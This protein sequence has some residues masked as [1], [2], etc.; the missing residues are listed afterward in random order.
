MIIR[1]LNIIATQNGE[2]RVLLKA[3]L[4]VATH[5]QTA[6]Q[7]PGV[8]SVAV[9]VWCT[10]YIIYLLEIASPKTQHNK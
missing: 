6:T 9:C 7:G 4:E 1:R 3:V 10:R 8:S 2:T 5:V